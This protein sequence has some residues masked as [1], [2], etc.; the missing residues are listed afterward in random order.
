M[1]HHLRKG[2]HVAVDHCTLDRNRGVR[3][4][5]CIGWYRVWCEQAECLHCGVVYWLPPERTAGSL[6]QPRL[7]TLTYYTDCSPPFHPLSVSVNLC[8]FL[9]GLLK[10]FFI[11]IT[12]NK[13]VNL[14]LRHR[15]FIWF[16]VNW[17]CVEFSCANRLLF[18]FTMI[19]LVRL[20]NHR[21]LKSF[22]ANKGIVATCL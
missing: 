16:A 22:S 14:W 7:L 4:Y 2:I 12:F 5:R 17:L 9:K 18:T 20:I 11:R 8:P 15:A 6:F 21:S 13:Y 1:L 19:V 10:G 3:L